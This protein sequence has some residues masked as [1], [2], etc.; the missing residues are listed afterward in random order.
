V[1]GKEIQHTIKFGFRGYRC[2]WMCSCGI[3]SSPYTTDTILGATRGS[4]AHLQKVGGDLTQEFV[5]VPYYELDK[6]ENS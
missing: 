1:D 5:S 3:G 6:K 4:Q 2:R